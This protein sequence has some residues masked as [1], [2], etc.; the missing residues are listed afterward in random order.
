MCTFP[1]IVLF[2]AHIFVCGALGDPPGIFHI[3]LLYCS[4]PGRISTL[5]C[6]PCAL[7]SF[8]PGVISRTIFEIGLRTRACQEPKTK[9]VATGSHTAPADLETILKSEPAVLFKSKPRHREACSSRRRCRSRNSSCYSR[10]HKVPTSPCLPALV[11]AQSPSL[12][13]RYVCD[14]SNES[15]DLEFHQR[16]CVCVL[17]MHI[18]PASP[19]LSVFVPCLPATCCRMLGCVCG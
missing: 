16:V 8:P 3:C 1:L 17:P 15:W 13:P 11:T 9:D 19:R 12:P 2:P 7:V 6:R 4:V 5:Y 14:P 18:P 10:R